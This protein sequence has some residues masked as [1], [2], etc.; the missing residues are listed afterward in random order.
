MDAMQATAADE[1]RSLPTIDSLSASIDAHL[2][3]GARTQ[4]FGNVDESKSWHEALA[5]QEGEGSAAIVYRLEGRVRKVDLTVSTESGD[6][7]LYATY[8]FRTNGTLARLDE[9]LNTFYGNISRMRVTFFNCAG[10]VLKTSI[11][12]ANLKTKQPFR[13]PPNDF[14]SEDAPCYKSV[15]ALPFSASRHR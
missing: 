4:F 13:V 15:D 11:R 2:P 14:I 7:V 10:V 8:Y 6:W 1:C 5:Y 12:Y 9:R 3:N